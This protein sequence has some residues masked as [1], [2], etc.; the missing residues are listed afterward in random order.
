MY[1]NAAGPRVGLGGMVRLLTYIVARRL[2]GAAACSHF[3]L[4]TAAALPMAIGVVALARH[5]AA[6]YFSAAAKR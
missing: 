4:L 2:R 3:A 5:T 6:R 1:M